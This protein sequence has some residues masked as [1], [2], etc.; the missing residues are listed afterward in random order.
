MAGAAGGPVDSVGVDSWGVDFALLDADGRLV[1]NPATTATGAG[2]S[3]GPRAR[4]RAGPRAL[5]THRDPAHAHQHGLR[6]GRHG[7]RARSRA[8][9]R[10]DAADDPRSH[11]I[12]GLAGRG[13]T[14]YTNATTTQCYD[15]RAGAWADDLLERLA[16]PTG[17]LPEVVAPGTTLGTLGRGSGRANRPRRC[18]CGRPGDARHRLCGRRD[19][20]PPSRLDLH[21]R[22][23]VVARRARARPAADRRPHLCRQ[24]HERG[25]RR[26]DRPAAA[27]R[28]RAL[29]PAR[30]P[31][32]VGARRPRLLVRVARRARRGSA[33]VRVAGRSRRPPLRRTGGHAAADPRLLHGERSGPARGARS[34]RALHPGEPGAEARADDRP[35]PR[36]DRRRPDR[37]ARRRRRR[38][39]R[40]A[41]PLD[42]GSG[43]APRARRARRRRPW[44]AICSSRRSRS[45]SSPRS[46]RPVRSFA[47]RSSRSSTSRRTRALGRRARPVRGARDGARPRTEVEA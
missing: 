9:R 16:V 14:E 31:A 17:L 22:G 23:Y 24:P 39:Q 42:R 30:V 33:R 35:H 19:P 45:A 40:V 25:R 41:L 44:S 3:N 7:R 43:G 18:Q 13:V 38:A 36:C 11:S 47:P 32:R 6:A 10:R 8:R 26:R 27:E 15:S 37:G 5:R 12:T 21:Q 46:T 29:A 20:V 2:P 1:Q 28:R 34:R 4:R